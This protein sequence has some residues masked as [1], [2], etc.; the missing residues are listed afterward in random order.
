MKIITATQG[1]DAWRLA[2]LGLPTASSAD[3]ILTPKKRELSKMRDAYVA[4]LV[5]EWALGRELMADSGTGGFMGRGS[6]EEGEALAWLEFDQGFDIERVGFCTLDDDSFGWSLDGYVRAQ[7]RNVE[8]KVPGP[9]A[10]VYNL[11]HPDEFVAEHFGQVQTGMMGNGASACWLVSYHATL[12]KVV[13]IVTRDDD[14]IGKFRAALAVV[15]R[16]IAAAKAE[17]ARLG[18]APQS[19]L[20]P[21]PAGVGSGDD[22]YTF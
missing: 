19:I 14:Y 4:R 7:N 6:K 1:D 9:A 8:T 16:E 18:F 20:V 12:P 10:H 13:R 17:M 22:G 3:S 5:S 21:E 11:L 15:T 2:R